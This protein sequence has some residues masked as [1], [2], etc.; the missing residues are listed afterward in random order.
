MSTWG[1]LLAIAKLGLGTS[2]T[3][4]ARFGWRHFVLLM[5]T[6]LV[7]LVVVKGVSRWRRALGLPDP[8][9]TG[10]RPTMP[11]EGDLAKDDPARQ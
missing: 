11:D 6:T 4:I 9:T 1:L 8:D 5:G 2:A 7:I 3:A 10:L